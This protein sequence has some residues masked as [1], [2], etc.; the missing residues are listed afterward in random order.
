L[1]SARQGGGS[2]WVKRLVDCPLNAKDDSHCLNHVNFS[3]PQ[4]TV[5]TIQPTI[6]RNVG[7][8]QW[9]CGYNACSPLVSQGGLELKENICVDG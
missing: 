8:Q 7:M 2:F 3:H 9:P 6:I 5:P 1:C 4:V